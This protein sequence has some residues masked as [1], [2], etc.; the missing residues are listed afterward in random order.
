MNDPY[1][2]GDRADEVTEEDREEDRKEQVRIWGLI[3]QCL[4]ENNVTASSAVNVC[5]NVFLHSI[6]LAGCPVLEFEELIRQIQVIGRKI[7]EPHEQV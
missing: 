2:I 4:E 5:L 3:Y 6:K 7:G 1:Y